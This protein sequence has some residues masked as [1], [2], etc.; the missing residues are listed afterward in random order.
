MLEYLRITNEGTLPDINRLKPYK[1]V[2]VVET[3]ISSDRQAEISRW[4]VGSGC[5]YM[6]A[7]GRECSSWDN[8]VDFANLEEFSYGEI[9]DD[10]FVMTTW[11]ESEPLEEVFWFAKNSAFHPS[12]E[13]DNTLILHLGENDKSEEFKNQFKNA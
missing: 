7:W 5:L 12:I 3:N 8:S 6:M 11:H 10:A 9:P 4:L 2:V 1:S 13:L